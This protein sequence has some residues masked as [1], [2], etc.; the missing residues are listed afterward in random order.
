MFHGLLTWITQG[1]KWPDIT[2]QRK[3][4]GKPL[5]ET[6]SMVLQTKHY[7]VL[8]NECWLWLGTKTKTGYG[9]VKIGRTSRMA[10][11][12]MYEQLVGRIPSGLEIDH[13][14]RN[15]SCVNPKHLEPVTHSENML[16]YSP[17]D[18]RVLSLLCHRGHLLDRKHK[19]G[20]RYCKK[21]NTENKARW[22]ARSSV[23]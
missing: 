15:K 16:R 22:R 17:Y 18:K 1:D 23:D 14:C 19:D 4:A 9:F 3:D 6:G 21:C 20:R 10:H 2:S 13:L 11:R 8:D 5:E 12:V 7:R